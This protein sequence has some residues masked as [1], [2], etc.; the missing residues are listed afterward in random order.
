MDHHR[1]QLPSFY[2]ESPGPK[3][4]W[5]KAEALPKLT[6]PTL[7]HSSS[8]Q[9]RQSI[10]RAGLQPNPGRLGNYV[11]ATFTE[12][13]ARRIGEHYEQRRGQS[14]DVWKMEVSDSAVRKV[15]RH[16]AWAGMSDFQEVCVD[17]V[18][19]Q[20]LKRVGDGLQTCHGCA[21]ELPEIY[22][23]EGLCWKCLVARNLRRM[24]QD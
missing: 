6:M 1:G 16:P 23:D 11:Y 18:A 5:L 24:A 9:N 21:A 3:H 20:Q 8:S 2:Q 4:N 15:E 10:E 14:Q 22:Q 7:Y 17:R 12:G 19:P 13:Q